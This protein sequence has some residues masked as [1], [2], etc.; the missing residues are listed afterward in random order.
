M[1]PFE[2]FT[3]PFFDLNYKA[4]HATVAG[5]FLSTPDPVKRGKK[6]LYVHIPFCDDI[7]EFCPF[8]KSVG[9]PERIDNYMAALAVELHTLG[10]T[11]RVA[12]WELDAVYIG[13]GTPSVLNV[14]QIATLFG[15]IR[16]N[17]TIKPDAEISFE[18]EAKSIDEHKLV[19]LKELGATRVSFGVQSFDPATRGMI[20]ITATL[21]QVHAAIAASVRHFANTNLDMMVGFPGQGLDDVLKD[22]ALAATSGIGSVSIYPVDYVMTLPSWLGRIRSGEL[23]RPAPLAE[24]DAM[25][26]QA[27]L[28]LGRHM[29]EQNMYCYGQ[30]GAPATKYMFSLLYGGYHDECVGAG[31]GAYSVIRGLAY[32]NEP[33]EPRYVKQAGSGTLPIVESSPGHAYEKGLVFFPKRL[34]FDMRDLQ[35]LGLAEVYKDRIES[36]VARGLAVVDGD[37]LRLTKEGY[38]L[39]SE[40]MVHFMSDTQ[41]RIYGRMC[42]RLREQVGVVDDDEWTAGAARV[43]QMGAY[44]AMGPAPAPRVPALAR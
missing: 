28:E 35:D 17:F 19:V 13:G 3:Y 7:C 29:S 37:T 8:V 27:R 1:I 30:P 14:E 41:R 20:N 15:V 43:Q 11:P 9:S 39:Y 16:K 26:H 4:D 42:E 22:A 38:P 31:A 44:S 23:P 36:V 40:L 32:R 24:R 2:S 34:T 5:A 21:D 10:A 6:G 18:F 33:K 12:A 25:F